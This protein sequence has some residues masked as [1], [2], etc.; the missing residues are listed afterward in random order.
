[1]GYELKIK[2]FE[3]LK[4]ADDLVGVKMPYTETIQLINEQID[5]TILSNLSDNQLLN[6]YYQIK[7]ELERRNLKE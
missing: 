7:D 6:F 4:N 3:I 5:K 1:M 2:P